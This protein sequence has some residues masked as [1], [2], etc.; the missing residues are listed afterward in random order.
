MWKCDK[1][2]NTCPLRGSLCDKLLQSSRQLP[3][4]LTR[5][6][7][8]VLSSFWP[9]PCHVVT[10][11]TPVMFARLQHSAFLFRFIV[12]RLS[13]LG[14]APVSH[15]MAVLSDKLAFSGLRP[16]AYKKSG[17]VVRKTEILN[18]QGFF[19]GHPSL[20]EKKTTEEVGKQ[21]ILN[22]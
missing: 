11:P 15:R 6:R 5:H 18:L 9:S 7:C 12:S 19:L 21:E 10:L 2:L 20:C 17:K 4:K 1:F 22:F 3:Q 8:I 16:A 13:I 14:F